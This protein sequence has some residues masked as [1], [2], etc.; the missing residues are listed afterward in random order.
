MS[1]R[2]TTFFKKKQP[3]LQTPN[4]DIRLNKQ[5]LLNYFILGNSGSLKMSSEEQ[6]IQKESFLHN[7]K[8]AETGLKF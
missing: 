3:E 7:N 6:H 1:A 2:L 5:A 8:T 4:H